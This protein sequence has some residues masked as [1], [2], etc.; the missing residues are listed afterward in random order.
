MWGQGCVSRILNISKEGSMPGNLRPATCNLQVTLP[1]TTTT[2]FLSYELVSWPPAALCT[3]LTPIASRSHDDTLWGNTTRKL[4]SCW[5]LIPSPGDGG[6]KE[7]IEKQK[8]KRKICAL[9]CFVLWHNTKSWS[10]IKMHIFILILT[11]NNKARFVFPFII[12]NRDGKGLKLTK[13]RRTKLQ[14]KKL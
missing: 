5:C 1:L 3:L 2:V 6:G 9:L 10:N 4:C 11:L 7:N 13:W 14:A 12:C 8:V